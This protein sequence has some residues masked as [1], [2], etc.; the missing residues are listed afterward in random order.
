MIFKNSF[1]QIGWIFIES[2]D[3]M[4]FDMENIMLS[5][6]GSEF[7]K[8]EKFSKKMM[9]ESSFEDMNF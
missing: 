9:I 3:E 7:L 8:F 2:M 4:S 1:L 5:F 6:N